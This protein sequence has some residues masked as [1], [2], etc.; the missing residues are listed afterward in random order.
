MGFDL[1]QYASAHID[2]ERLHLFVEQLHTALDVVLSLA[3]EE[4]FL[5]ACLAFVV[6]T[7]SSHSGLGRAL[8]AV[9]ISIWS[10]LLICVV[11]GSSLW[12]ILALMALLPIFE[13]MS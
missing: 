9:M 13:W 5:I 2:I 3:L 8:S 10:P 4:T 11:I 1:S 7:T 6:V 12:L